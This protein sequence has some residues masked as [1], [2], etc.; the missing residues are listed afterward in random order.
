MCRGSSSG[1]QPRAKLTTVNGS[2]RIGTKALTARTAKTMLTA[3]NTQATPPYNTV[4]STAVK[5][6]G[7][8]EV[9]RDR[10]RR[11]GAVMERLS[12]LDASFLYLETPSLH[13]H[14]ALTLVFDPSTVPGGY[15]FDRMKE[16]DRGP[17]PVR[18]G[19]PAA[20]DGGAVP[21]RSPGVGGRRRLRHRLPRPPGGRPAP[22]GSASWPTWPATSPAASSTG[23][24]PCGRCGS[25]RASPTAASASSPRCTTRRWTASRG[26]RCSRC[27]ST[28]SPSPRPE[29]PPTRP[30]RWTPAMPSGFE[31]MS[32]AVVARTLRP[33]EI[34]HDM[35]RTGQRRPQRPAGPP[36]TA[37]RR[38]D[39][40]QGRPPPLRAP[41]L[42]Q[43]APS[44][45]GAAWP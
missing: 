9:A 42:V 30:C 17:H 32:Q 22:A 41:N 5:P 19:V 23:R 45:G 37:D 18:P 44:P 29:M 21:A 33:L 38:L 43:R 27:S 39:P 7:C 35:V 1:I 16:V 11:E 26:P 10:T 13:M 20:P 12:G 40:G 3:R 2:R 36:G 34:T 31:L 6:T 8:R 25:S 4:R 15:S 14:V 28:S 24:S